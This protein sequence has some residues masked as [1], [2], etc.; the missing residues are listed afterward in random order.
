MNNE[1]YLIDCDNQVIGNEIQRLCVMADIQPPELPRQTAEFIKENFGQL[2]FDSFTRAINYWL[3]GKMPTL[4][5]PIKINAHFLSLMLRDYFET[6][7][8]NIKLKP[9]PMLKA[10]EKVV[11]EE[12]RKENHKRFYNQL[13]LDFQKA[14]NG[15]VRLIPFTMHLLGQTLKDECKYEITNREKEEALEWLQNYEKRRDLHIQNSSKKGYEIIK[16]IQQ[17]QKFPAS[18]ERIETI[19]LTYTH[20]KKLISGT[21][22]KLF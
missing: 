1:I 8:H 18:F 13:L 6:F 9:R 2:P 7:R 22:K 10:P 14:Q 12:E 15:D 11:T 17:T 5:K 3:S 21:E 19:A 20:F 16:K 4:K